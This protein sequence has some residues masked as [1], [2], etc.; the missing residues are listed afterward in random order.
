M[1][2][3]C[4]GT[5]DPDD[6]WRAHPDNDDARRLGRHA[7]SR[8]P[9]RV[10]AAEA[11]G[12]ALGVEPEPD[13]VVRDAA[14]GAAAARRGRDRRALKVVMDAANLEPGDADV[15]RSWRSRC[16]AATSSSRTRRTSA[17]PVDYPLYLSLLRDAGFGGPLVL[18]GMPETEV[19][20]AV[21][22][23]AAL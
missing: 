8:S 6:M 7:S 4:T 1:V 13:N 23:L 16:S 18:H 21:D 17:A 20:A 14:G 12:V 19:A 15:L 22:F 3:L 11:A 5:R 10:A 9:P 2:T